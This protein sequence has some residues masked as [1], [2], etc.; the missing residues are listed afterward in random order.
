MPHSH[1]SHS[2]QFCIHAAGTLQEGVLE[3]IRQGFQVYGLTE[4]KSITPEEFAL[5]FEHFLVE[6]HRIKLTHYITPLDLEELDSL[7]QRRR[8]LVE[9]IVGSVHHV[10]GI[11]IDFDLVTFRKAVES[12]EST[13]PATKDGGFLSVKPEIIEHLDLCRLYNSTLQLSEYPEALARVERNI[14]YAV[15]YEASFEINASALHKGWSTPYP[16]EDLL[17]IIL[18]HGGRLILS[19]DSHGPHDRAG[20]TELWFL[21]HS[22]TPN[23]S[24]RNI[25]ATKMDRP[26]A[27]D[28][29]WTRFS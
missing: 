22:E 4:C 16:G 7:L 3:A 10:N 6:A 14:I 23:A 8:G 1:H 20:V 11:P 17:Q 27:A 21:E 5:Q 29:F 26:W 12:M 28:A 25:K 18:K 19:N 15:R 24:G 2:G 13:L 9:Y